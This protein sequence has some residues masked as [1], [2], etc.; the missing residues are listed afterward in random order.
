[1]L[2]LLNPIGIGIVLLSWFVSF[3]L[4]RKLT[5]KK[6]KILAMGTMTQ[7]M[8]FL[9]A[10]V[11]AFYFVGNLN[12]LEKFGHGLALS[13]FLVVIGTVVKIICELIGRLKVTN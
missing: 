7:N 13:L 1:M 5:S 10:F 2:W 12:D 4:F 3:I 8:C 11:S 6:E 9:V